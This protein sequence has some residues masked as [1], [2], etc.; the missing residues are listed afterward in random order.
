MQLFIAHFDD[1]SAFAAALLSQITTRMPLYQEFNSSR[2]AL[3]DH[4]SALGAIAASA[5]KTRQIRSG[6]G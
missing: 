5:G 2:F 6:S 1:L 3:T 4:E